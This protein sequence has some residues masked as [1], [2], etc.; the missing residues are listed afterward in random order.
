MENTLLIGLSRQMTLER[1][2]DVVANNVANVNTTG[3]KADKSLFEEYLTSGAHEDNFSGRD[4]RV[5]YVTDR[6]TYHDLSQGRVEE[7]KNPLDI[8]I[9]GKGFLVVQT[10]G[11]ERYTRDGNLQINAQ[12]QLVTASGYPVLGNSGPIVFQS[13]DKE[14]SINAEGGV[15]VL[16]GVNRIDS[17]R[18]KLRIVSFAQPQKLTKQGANLY[19]PGTGNAAQADTTSRVRQGFVEKSNVNSVSEMSK[20]IEVT[21]AYTQISALLQQQGDL[22]KSALDKLADVPA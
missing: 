22:R 8:A 9:D 1:Q 17:I 18:G 5:S 12:G 10:P 19:A 20:M 11:G 4:R 15:S 14:I 3:Y 21:R 13:T 16:E 6:A 2:M 7:T